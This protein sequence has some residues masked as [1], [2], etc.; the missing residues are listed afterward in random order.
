MRGGHRGSG[1]REAAPRTTAPQHTPHHH[2]TAQAHRHHTQ[3]AHPQPVACPRDGGYTHIHTHT[4]TPP[5]TASGRQTLATRPEDGQPGEGER[6]M[7][8]APHNGAEHPPP[9]TPSSHPNSAQRRLARAHAVGL[10]LGPH[11]HATRARKTRAT[12]PGRPP[13]G[14][15]AGRGRAP[16]TRRPSQR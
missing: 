14:R 4:R 15:A 7:P 2:A 16:D 8:D 1:S 13:Q 12:G 10:V 9:G 11:A 6:L 3:H 5:P